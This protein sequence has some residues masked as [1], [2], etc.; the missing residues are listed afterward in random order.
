MSAVGMAGGRRIS[1][2]LSDA[3]AKMALRRDALK[4]RR[5]TR[6]GSPPVALT[7]SLYTAKLLPGL[8]VRHRRPAAP[9]A[10]RTGG[11]VVEGA[12]LESVYT[13]QA[14]RG[15]ESR[16]VRRDTPTYSSFDHRRRHL[17]PV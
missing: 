12:R 17:T 11:R 6:G 7:S 14:Y 2:C 4:I 3:H 8:K 10:S 1:I 5:R 16:P 9:T 15:F 13:S